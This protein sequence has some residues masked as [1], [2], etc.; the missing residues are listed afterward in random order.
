LD[1]QNFLSSLERIQPTYEHKSLHLGALL[2]RVF[3]FLKAALFVRRSW[4]QSLLL[5]NAVVS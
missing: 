5:L 2:L 4:K 1:L 3:E